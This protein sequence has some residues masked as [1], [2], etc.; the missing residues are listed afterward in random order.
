M[1][2]GC[3]GSFST[4]DAP[5]DV[6]IVH[7]MARHSLQFVSEMNQNIE[8]IILL[9]ATMVACVRARACVCARDPC[10]LRVME[11]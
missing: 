11:V 6:S 10:S 4:G 9:P 7:A 8:I 2:G 3:R 5:M 1:D